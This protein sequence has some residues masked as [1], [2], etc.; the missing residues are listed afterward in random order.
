MS[1]S[2]FTIPSAYRHFS[3][4]QWAALRTEAPNVLSESEVIALRGSGEVIALEEVKRIY[5][6]LSRLLNLYVGV[7]QDLHR[8]TSSFLGQLQPKVPYIIGLAGSVAVGKSTTARILQA[9][10]ARWPNHPKVELITTDGF[11]HSNAVLEEK[12]IAERKGFPE[13]FDTRTLISF[14]NAV[15]SG[16]GNVQAPVYSHE[17]YD[18]LPGEYLLINQPDILIVEGLNVLQIPHKKEGSEA[19]PAISDFFD[20]SIYLDAEVEHIEQW[21]LERLLNLRATAFKD[22][23]AYFHG[24]AQQDEDDVIAFARNIWKTINE[25]N[26]QQNILPTRERAQLILRKNKTHRI[27]DIYLRKL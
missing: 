3:A 9:L 10:L 15:K 18:I 23:Q 12:G 19:L 6:P 22:P 27:S 20:F 26:L 13:S 25:Q 7:T 11:L 17:F 4:R 24:L 1:D 2:A 5:L 21:F 16:K 8:V 14:L